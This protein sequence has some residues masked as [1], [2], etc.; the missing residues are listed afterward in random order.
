MLTKL[1]K[2]KNFLVGS[3]IALFFAV[4]CLIVFIPSTNL[5]AEKIYSHLFPGNALFERNI[6]MK[7]NENGNA[8]AIN[9]FTGCLK[10][11]LVALGTMT[12]GTTNTFELMDDAET[13]WA[14]TNARTTCTS[15][16]D[17]YKAG[18]SSLK[19]LFDASAVAGDGATR[20]IA[21]INM[22]ND[23]SV[24]FWIYSNLRLPAASFYIE[25]FDNTSIVDCTANLPEIPRAAW[26]WVE[27]DFSG[28][29]GVDKDNV[30][31]VIL[32][33]STA[34]ATNLGEVSVYMDAMFGWAPADE[35]ALGKNL[36]TDGVSSVMTVLTAQGGANTIL[37]L[38]QYTDY[39]VN[40]QAGN[41][42][43]V[44]ITD[45]STYSGIAMISYQ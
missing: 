6:F 24:G 45:Q 36:M 16:T 19:T 10:T 25:L 9:E 43:T 42:V 40:Y 44:T 2:R 12:N 26:T 11:K 17:M 31:K 35:E 8:G 27:L 14:A 33:M 32:K 38:T 3:L 34:G 39:F 41:D 15:D 23:E 7:P 28:C 4:T 30:S 22:Q 21:A 20:T 37:L 1:F 13:G 5:V 29:A 18:A